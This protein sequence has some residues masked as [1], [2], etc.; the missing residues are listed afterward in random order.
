MYRIVTIR[1]R[2]SVVDGGKEVGNFPILEQAK[3][4]IDSERWRNEKARQVHVLNTGDKA[5]GNIGDDRHSGNIRKGSKATSDKIR[6][7]KKKS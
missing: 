7:K 2:F 5:L 1:G 4:F 3:A 6:G